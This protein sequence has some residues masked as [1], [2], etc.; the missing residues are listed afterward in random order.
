MREKTL[1]QLERC[2]FGAWF[3]ETY[4]S[5]GRRFDGQRIL[6]LE[7][8]MDRFG[9]SVRYYIETKNPEEAEGLE[10]SLI[11]ILDRYDLLDAGNES[12]LIFQ[13]FSKESLVALAEKAPAIPRVRLLDQKQLRPPYDDELSEISAYADGIGPHYG[14]VVA[15]LVAAAVV[16]SCRD[17][18]SMEEHPLRP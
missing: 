15:A 6:T 8:L 5:V 16:S 7:A 12:R 3:G 2:D 9:G 14:D 1:A 13:S 11:S 17:C 10:A 18:I 4:P